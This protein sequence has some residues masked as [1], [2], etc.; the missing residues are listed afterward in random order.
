MINW[1]ITKINQDNSKV[2]QWIEIIQNKE[3]C[4]KRNKQEDY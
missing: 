4:L 3:K 1:I 2:L